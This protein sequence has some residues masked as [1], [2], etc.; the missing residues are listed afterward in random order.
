VV[1]YD[2]QNCIRP[3]ENLVFHNCSKYIDIQYQF[4]RDRVQKG[5]MV[6]EY[7]PLD[8]LVTNLLTKPTTKGILRCL[9]RDWVSWRTLSLQGE[10]VRFCTCCSVSDSPNHGVVEKIVEMV[11]LVLTCSNDEQVE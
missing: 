7:I 3:F 1:Y 5:A 10:S 9:G 8:L 11:S 4:L 6:L 2:N